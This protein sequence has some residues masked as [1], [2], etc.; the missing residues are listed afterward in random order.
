MKMN[1][2]QTVITFDD[3]SPERDMLGCH[4]EIHRCET[5]HSHALPGVF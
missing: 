2:L 5:A 3:V 4:C 1:L